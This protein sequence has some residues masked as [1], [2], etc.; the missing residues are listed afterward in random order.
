MSKPAAARPRALAAFVLLGGLSALVSANGCGR[1]DGPRPDPR[2]APGDVVRFQ[3]EALAADEEAS[4]IARAFRFA[5]PANQQMT[6]G[7]ERFITIVRAPDYRP[8]LNHRHAE[9][10]DLYRRNA[11]AAQVVELTAADGSY[12]R[13]LFELSR[14]AHGRLAGCWLTDAVHKLEVEEP[15]RIAL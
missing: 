14:Q 12:H 11:Y 1:E 13:Y 10:S 8:M 9:A 5:S 4:G 6:G 15:E 3:L 7:L 2:H